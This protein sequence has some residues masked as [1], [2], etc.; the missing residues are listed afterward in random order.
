[1]SKYSVTKGKV[2]GH[3]FKLIFFSR[4]HMENDF[5]QKFICKLL[6]Q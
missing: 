6:F 5:M 2:G 3:C 4:N 1:M